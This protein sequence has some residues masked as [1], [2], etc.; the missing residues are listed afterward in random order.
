MSVRS[1]W[2][3]CGVF[4]FA[5]ALIFVTGNMT[6]LIATVIGF[7]AFGLT[8]MGMMN[9]LPTMVSHV[10]HPEP[11]KKVE[12]TAIQPIRETPANAFHVFK[13]A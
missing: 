12:T 8:F 2:F 3:V 4:V 10:T 6:M 1:Y 11:A 5:T 7:L 9:V 13:S